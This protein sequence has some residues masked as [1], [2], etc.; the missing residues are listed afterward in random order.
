M[1]YVDQVFINELTKV[2]PYLIP[3]SFHQKYS[4]AR[5][6]CC[7]HKQQS[8]IELAESL[9]YNHYNFVQY[10]SVLCCICSEVFHE[11][12]HFYCVDILVPTSNKYCLV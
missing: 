1:Y 2:D 4:T 8:Q 10:G 11:S 3:F 9:G 12:L 6:V 7:A 5:L